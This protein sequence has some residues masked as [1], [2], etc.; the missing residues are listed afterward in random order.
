MTGPPFTPI[1]ALQGEPSSGR[2]SI[3]TPALVGGLFSR[4]QI[5]SITDGLTN[6]IIK[7]GGISIILCILGMCIFLVKEVI[8]LFQPPHATPAEP[9]TLSQ[10]EHS[11]APA[12]IG[13]D[14]HQEL[15]YAL[16]DDLL[17]FVF[18]GGA[19]SAVSHIPSRSLL[20]DGSVTALARAFGKGHQLAMGTE[21]GRVIPVTIEF[22]QDF[23]GNERSIAPSVTVG[24]PMVAALT[25][26]P[27]TK[28]AYQSTDS[29]VRVAALLQDQHLWLTTSRNTSRPDGTAA[30]SITQIDLT[31]SIPGRVTALTLAS[32]AELLAVGTEEGK[33]YHFDLR[34]PAKPGLV[35]TTQASEG[36]D[37]ITALAYL[38]SDRSLVVGG[39]SGQ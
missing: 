33:V 22:T 34:E 38:M 19:T 29:E 15:A 12:L 13:I 10:L 39:A 20:P 1:P 5:R 16:R 8:P 9:I 25:P 23:Q 17:E 3:P 36:S 6:V 35:E 2:G 21:D 18:L 14:E 31:P 32:R 26:Q 7:A 30:A 11:S 24:T 37:A 27:I 28:M 4:R